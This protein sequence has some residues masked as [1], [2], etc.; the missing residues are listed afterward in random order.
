VSS[1][2][3]PWPDTA[4]RLLRPRLLGLAL[5]LF[6]LLVYL[7]T[8]QHGFI[9]YDDPDYVTDNRFVQ[10]GLTW[11]GVKWAFTTFSVSNWHP[12]TWV[13]HMLDCECFDLDPAAHHLV[14][15]V[16]HATN[17]ALLMVLLAR[18]T[19][20]L[21][22]SAFVTALFAWHPLHI[23]SVA[24]VSERKDLLST[25][26]WILTVLAY[27]AYVRRSTV[28]GPQSLSSVPARQATRP[29]AWQANWGLWAPDTGPRTRIW[30][31]TA[32][33]MFALGL[34]SK[35]ML[36]TLPFTLLL[37]DY[38][39]LRR[40]SK[41][42]GSSRS[43]WKRL[44]GEKSPFFVLS[45]LSCVLTL[46]AQ[47]R[48]AIV[49]LVP[50]PLAWRIENALVSYVRYLLKTIYP[51][52]LA[53]I[54]PLPHGWPMVTVAAAAAVLVLLSYLAWRM[55]ATRP[56]LLVGWLWFVGTLVPVI[57]LV[58]VGGQALADRYTYVPLLGIFIAVSF[59][60]RFWLERWSSSPVASGSLCAVLL[61]GCVWLTEKQ[62][63]YWMDSRA[64]FAQALAVTADNPIA[65]VNLGMVLEQAGRQ[66]DALNHYEE[67]IQLNPALLQ[68]HN[69]LANLYDRLGRFQEALAQYQQALQLK[70]MSPLVHANLGRLLARLGSLDDAVHHYHEAV[71]LD[72]GDPRFHYELGK[73]LLR[74]GQAAEAVAQL[75]QALKLGPNDLTTK[76]FLARVLAA[77]N[78]SDVR[79]ARQAVALAELA[80]ALT[81]GEQPFVLDTLAMAYAESGRFVDAQHTVQKAIDRTNKDADADAVVSMRKRLALYEAA[82]PYR[83]AFTNADAA[84]LT[85]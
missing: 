52:Q 71:R 58:Q 19:G 24:W 23:E 50:Y 78:E 48:E 64:L 55:R 3:H 49:A 80:N 67:A 36:V 34:M 6:T 54:Y 40:L 82:Q 1:S 62:L 47:R 38:W 11:A 69:N 15:V 39:P 53:V 74:R 31:W 27:F 79:D 84:Q 4:A 8:R 85:R 26:F 75:Q 17:T 21:W 77:N 20:A 66:D 33:V 56:H 73:L 72:P 68:A 37:L 57:G 63:K 7:P 2:A 32:L 60:G 29:R 41:T 44:V 22:T 35:P 61:V 16:L 10:A 83:E 51:I 70:P 46:L 12:L 25:L 9:V 65:H 28:L 43:T 30:Y 59:E 5:G 42:G 81:G 45:L 76:V 14:N 13:S 18:L